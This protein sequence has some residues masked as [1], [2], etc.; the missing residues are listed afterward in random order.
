[1]VSDV[2]T[3]IK[4]GFLTDCKNVFLVVVRKRHLQKSVPVAPNNPLAMMLL[5]E[6]RQLQPPPEVVEL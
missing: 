5:L 6:G 3:D 1:M 4:D 2:L